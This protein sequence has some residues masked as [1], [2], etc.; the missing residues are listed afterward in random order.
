MSDETTSISNQDGDGRPARY[1]VGSVARALKIL[2]L[3]AD[4]PLQG[5]TLS[6]ATRG[7][8]ISKSATYSLMRTLVDADFLRAV[9]PGPRYCLGPS[10]TRLGELAAS[11]R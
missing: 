1:R 4:G 8:G 9:D 10:L 11:D 3:V 5:L 2:D 6:E 7:L